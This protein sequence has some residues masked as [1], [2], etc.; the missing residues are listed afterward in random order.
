MLY[1]ETGQYKTGYAADQALFPIP[2]DRYGVALI[3]AIGIVAFL[4][5]KAATFMTG[6]IVVADGGRMT[7]NYTVP[8]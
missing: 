1:R 7:L 8:V 2:L 4:A 5:S 3:L 6:Q